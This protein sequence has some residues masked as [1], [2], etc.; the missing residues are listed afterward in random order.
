[1][2]SCRSGLALRFFYLIRDDVF[3][4][5]DRSKFFDFIIPVVPFVDASNSCDQLLERFE[6]AG[7]EVKVCVLFRIEQFNTHEPIQIHFCERY[8]KWIG[9][10][11]VSKRF[12]GKD[13]QPAP[14]S[15]SGEKPSALLYPAKRQS[16]LDMHGLMVLTFLTLIV[17]GI[18]VVQFQKWV[19]TVERS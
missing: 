1:M 8:P 5:S 4:A 14:A 13:H 17:T 2:A 10:Q 3:T 16:I 7:F 19:S 9:P 15:N 12:G 6:K 11:G 18:Y